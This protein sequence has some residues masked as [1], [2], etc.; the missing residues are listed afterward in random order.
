M[1]TNRIVDKGITEGEEDKILIV[2]LQGN[3]LL[4]YVSG[5]SRVQVHPFLKVACTHCDKEYYNNPLVGYC[6]CEGGRYAAARDAHNAY[7]ELRRGRPYCTIHNAVMWRD[8]HRSRWVCD[9]CE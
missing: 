7:P 3:V 2:D 6:N 8:A 1:A 9:G 5:S 4:S